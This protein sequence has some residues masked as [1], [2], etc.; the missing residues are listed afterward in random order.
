VHTHSL[1]NRVYWSSCISKSEELG[2]IRRLQEEQASEFA[3]TTGA[4][5]TGRRVSGL[6]EL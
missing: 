3:P 2:Q 5:R 6:T 1:F 4:A